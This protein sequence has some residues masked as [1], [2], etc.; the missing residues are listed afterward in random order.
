MCRMRRVRQ[1]QKF[2]LRYLELCR[3]V[4]EYLSHSHPFKCSSHDVS[5]MAK[6]V[7]ENTQKKSLRK[8]LLGSRFHGSI[9]LEH[10]NP[11]NKVCNQQKLATAISLVSNN[12]K[13]VVV[14]CFSE[15]SKTH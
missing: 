14:C 5:V 12:L 13:L 15:K 8:V 6:D 11:L 10:F 2:N 7:W 1:G 9:L 4:A 3:L